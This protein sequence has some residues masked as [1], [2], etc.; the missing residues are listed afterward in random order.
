MDVGV[1]IVNASIIIPCYNHGRF[2]GESIESCLKQ[3][4]KPMEII[5]VDD[6]STDDSLLVAKSYDKQ[7]V[8]VIHQKNQG[9]SSARN[10]GI[11]ASKGAFILTLDADDTIHK[12]FLNK[13]IFVD[14]IVSTSV[15]YFGAMEFI[16]HP[17]KEHPQ[18]SDFYKHNHI[19]C[20]SLYKREVFYAIGGYDEKMLDG[21]E[22]WDFWLRA[23]KAGYSVTVIKEPLFNYRKHPNGSMI[24]HAKKH[25]RK[26][27][28][29]IKS[30][31][32]LNA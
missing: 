18:F 6:G 27:E 30:K 1:C 3:T 10:A 17:V 23:T 25:Y 2:L 4:L 13:T 9:L 26:T 5:V 29:Y 31:I 28:Q 22:D 16:K 21:L 12:D 7:G 19:N 24:D 8:K 15:Q 11:R 20:C 32:Q 14:D